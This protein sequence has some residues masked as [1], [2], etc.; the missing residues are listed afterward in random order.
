MEVFLQ[1]HDLM[2]LLKPIQENDFTT[3]EEL[4]TLSDSDL[5]EL[6]ISL[7]DKIR[8]KKALNTL[9]S[10][11]EVDEEVEGEDDDDEVSFEDEEE[12]DD[13]EDYQEC[14]GFTLTTETDI[15]LFDP[16]VE[17]IRRLVWDD[18]ERGVF[19]I[20]EHGDD[21]RFMQA[22]LIHQEDAGGFELEF[23]DASGKN[24]FSTT[25]LVSRHELLDALVKYGTGDN[26]WRK[27]HAWK[28][29]THKKSDQEIQVEVEK[30]EEISPDEQFHE[31]LQS[32][33]PNDRIYVA[34]NIPSD[35]F[36][37]AY[38]SY[39]K[40]PGI[41]AYLMHDVTV[42]GGSKDGIIL[43]K[44]GIYLKDFAEKPS[45]YQ[46][47]DIRKIERQ[48]LKILINGEKK[49]ICLGIS[50]ESLDTIIRMI[51]VKSGIDSNGDTIIGKKSPKG[52]VNLVL[53][54]CGSNKIKLIEEVRKIRP[55]L[56]LAD[57]KALV[58]NLPQV[59]SQEISLDEAQRLQKMIEATGSKVEI[60]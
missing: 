23:N 13:E 15:T 9:M 12:L 18:D 14:T 32:L 31:I 45:F 33:P 3:P 5:G 2:K 25:E 60:Q 34:P 19:L 36:N 38:N 35:K 44:D 59:I 7:G 51:K 57:A 52:I 41:E 50:E 29:T 48:K 40:R 24:H 4:L 28:K 30:T 11:E 58:E 49:L 1:Q 39:V 27:S 37:A 43:A 55:A 47:S 21:G 56:G 16:S 20:L 8:L 54:Y 42:F 17:D 26:S 10:A 46:Y 53:I 22:L 6:G